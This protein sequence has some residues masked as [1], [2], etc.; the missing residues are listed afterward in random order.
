MRVERA[1]LDALVAAA[2]DARRW[3]EAVDSAGG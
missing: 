1:R 3:D 2:G